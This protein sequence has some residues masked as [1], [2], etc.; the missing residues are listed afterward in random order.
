[1]SLLS[2]S[3]ISWRIFIKF[4][5]KVTSLDVSWQIGQILCKRHLERDAPKDPECGS[6]WSW[7]L[8][9]IRQLVFTFPSYRSKQSARDCLRLVLLRLLRFVITRREQSTS[10]RISFEGF[11]PFNHR[12]A[13]GGVNEERKSSSLTFINVNGAFRC[14]CLMPVS[15]R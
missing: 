1:M 9:G 10:V 14:F 2:K 3:S 15:S 13:V 7:A 8:V 4:S 12:V 5:I 11:S 6:V